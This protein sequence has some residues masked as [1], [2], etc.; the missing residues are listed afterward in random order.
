MYQNLKIY[1]NYFTLAWLT[2]YWLTVDTGSEC[3]F[4]DSFCCRQIIRD[5]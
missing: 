2:L 4:I 3:N 5:G 1:Q